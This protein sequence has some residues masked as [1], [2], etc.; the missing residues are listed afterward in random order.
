MYD[1]TANT[2]DNRQAQKLTTV[3][4]A[5]TDSLAPVVCCCWSLG[6]NFASCFWRWQ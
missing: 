4:T 6:V 2:G 1:V 3:L 5:M